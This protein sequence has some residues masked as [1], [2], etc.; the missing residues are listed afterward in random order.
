MRKTGKNRGDGAIGG[1]SDS[2]LDPK[3]LE[4]R[5]EELERELAKARRANT[6]AYVE[7]ETAAA[8]QKLLS[9][10][11]ESLSD[12]FALFDSDDRLIFC[13]TIFKEINPE[14]ASSIR[15]GVTFEYML[16]DNVKHG[17]ILDAIGREEDF[18]RERMQRHRN[19]GKPILSARKDGRWLLLREERT[20]D[21]CTFLVN[22]DLTELKRREDALKKSEKRF[23]DFAELGS[24]WLWEMDENLRFK[25]MSPNIAEL[26][27]GIEV[28]IG[29]T[30]EETRHDNYD[31]GGLDEEMQALNARKPYCIERQSIST[32]RNWLRI[33]GKPLFSENGTF[34]GY[35]GATADIT[36]R[37]I[38]EEQKEASYRHLLESTNAI[39]WEADTKTWRFTYVGPQAEELL[40]YPREQWLEEDFWVDHLHPTDRTW[41]PDYCLNSLRNLEHYEFEYRMI[42]SGGQTIWLHDIVNVV[43]ENGEP[44]ALRGFLLEIGARK[45]AEETLQNLSARLINAHEDERRRIAR[46]LHDDFGQNL[47]I[48][49]VDLELFHDQLSGPEKSLSDFLESQIQRT[50]DISSKL[51]LLSRQ[52]HPSIIEHVGLVSA[53]LGFC[54]ELSDRHDIEVEVTHNG[55]SHAL[56]T[57]V[58][59]CLYRVVQEALRNVVKHS[60]AQ[61]A[62]VELNQTE[63]EVTLRISDTGKGFDPTSDQVYRGLGLLS[64][65]ERLRMVD[66]NIAI[67][68]IDPNGTQIDVRVPLQ[69]PAPGPGSTDTILERREG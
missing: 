29:N 60:G 5:I 24:D 61:T 49:T 64:M 27:V 56:S 30:L 9:G 53:V 18:V 40:G 67:T 51:Q 55:V 39:P 23:R 14:L 54:G 34:L 62:L 7:L 37:K 19:P 25:Y 46:E 48:L 13:N 66:G 57:D 31:S 59:L 11:F 17:R 26:G 63:K 15:P 20:P 68:Q 45:R 38:A 28:F 41:V 2:I 65:R 43:R 44:V 16:R 10:A 36:E 6:E 8:E 1:K 32:P 42:G 50:K 12:G 33:S 35:R 4:R 3:R 21:G 22:T 69:D 58:S 47:A 52:L